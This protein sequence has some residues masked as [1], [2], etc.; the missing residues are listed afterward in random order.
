MAKKS[1]NPTVRQINMNFIIRWKENNKPGTNLVSAGQYQKIVGEELK[2][3]HFKDV[4]E[5]G[6]DKYTFLIR[7]RLIIN[8]IA[9]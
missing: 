3:K 4:M 9:K 7:K 2:S 8:F 5:G 1:N 6:L